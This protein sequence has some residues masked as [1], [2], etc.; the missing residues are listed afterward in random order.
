[1]PLAI[2]GVLRGA[3]HA[4]TAD[5]MAKLRSGFKAASTMMGSFHATR[6]VGGGRLSAAQQGFDGEEQLSLAYFRDQEFFRLFTSGEYQGEQGKKGKKSKTIREVQRD[7]Q[8]EKREKAMEEKAGQDVG[9]G[10]YAVAMWAAGY[11][12]VVVWG[13]TF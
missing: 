8:R 10:I 2:G 7:M 3:A 1:M 12:G 9:S 4:G 6:H 5:N 11:M 13:S